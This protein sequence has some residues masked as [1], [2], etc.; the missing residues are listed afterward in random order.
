VFENRVLRI[1][2]GSKR[3]EVTEGWTTLCMCNVELGDLYGQ[4]VRTC[5]M[6]GGEEEGV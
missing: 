4:I 3:D 1:I 5:S 2:F 6:N